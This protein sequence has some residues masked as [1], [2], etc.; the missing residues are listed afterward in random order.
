MAVNNQPADDIDEPTHPT[1]PTPKEPLPGG[2][3]VGAGGR[4]G[5]SHSIELGE[6]HTIVLPQG[7]IS[8]PRFPGRVDLPVSLTIGAALRWLVSPDVSA[9]TMARAEAVRFS[10]L[11]LAADSV[12]SGIEAKGRPRE[13]LWMLWLDVTHQRSA[14]RYRPRRPSQGTSTTLPMFSRA[15]RIRCA[16]GASAN[17]TAA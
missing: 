15:A 17:G 14:V 1:E 4:V 7:R 2:A 8:G 13:T 10:T 9:S 3:N 5:G 6:P 11:E 16:S 12:P